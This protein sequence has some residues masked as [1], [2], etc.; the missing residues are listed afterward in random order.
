MRSRLNGVVVHGEKVSKG[1]SLSM[2]KE[3]F[4][5]CRN[6]GA[7][8]CVCV[9]ERVY[10]R[11]LTVG[12]IWV[13]CWLQILLSFFLLFLFLLRR[14]NFTSYSRETDYNETE[15]ERFVNLFIY[16]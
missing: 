6:G 13:I 8:V 15:R 11:G 7:D 14:A 2:S 10:T 9:R 3:V 12:P 4:K 5:F 16:L 1:L